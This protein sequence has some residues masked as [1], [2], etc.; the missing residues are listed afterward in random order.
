MVWRTP[1]QPIAKL[2]GAV[3]LK[4]RQLIQ[5]IIDVGC[6]A[7]IV[8]GMEVNW[9]GRFANDSTARH[10]VLPDFIVWLLFA[11]GPDWNTLSKTKVDL[12]NHA[13]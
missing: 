5:W 8:L 13:I 9:G 6:V 4:L 10:G 3:M 7:A 1:Q 2:T 11:C 12:H